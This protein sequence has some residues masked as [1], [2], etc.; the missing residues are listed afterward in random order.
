MYCHMSG[1]VGSLAEGLVTNLAFVFP[2]PLVLENVILQ[3][4][5][6]LVHVWAHGTLV[7]AIRVYLLRTILLF[8]T[9]LNP[10]P[11]IAKTWTYVNV[12]VQSLPGSALFV[13]DL[14]DV[15]FGVDVGMVTS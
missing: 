4:R 11:A 2:D 7:P 15:F 8:I 10:H 13:A 3:H 12:I 6:I 1:D 14:A 5:A 9:A